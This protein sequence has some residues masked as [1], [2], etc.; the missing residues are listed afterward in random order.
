VLPHPRGY[1]LE[2]RSHRAELARDHLVQGELA[3]EPGFVR[4]EDLV[5][6]ELEE[7][8]VQNVDLGD[9]SVPVEGDVQRATSPLRTCWRNLPR[10]GTSNSTE[11][12]G[13]SPS[14][15]PAAVPTRRSPA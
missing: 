3:P 9:G 10:T 1:L 8:E 13:P 11:S 6:A 12:S 7:D 15:L 2:R 14:T 4:L 5:V